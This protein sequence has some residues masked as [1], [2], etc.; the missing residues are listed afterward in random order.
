[1]PVSSAVPE[2]GTV[3]DLSDRNQQVVITVPGDVLTV[4]LIGAADGRMQWS[5]RSPISGGYLTMKAHTV[6][7]EDARISSGEQLSEWTFKVEQAATFPLRF[8]YHNPASKLAP[9]KVFSVLVVAD[10]TEA[11]LAAVLADIEKLQATGGTAVIGGFA[12]AGVEQVRYL[13]KDEAGATVASG[14]IPVPD[15]DAGFRHFEKT[16]WFALPRTPN[17]ALVLTPSV[18]DSSDTPQPMTV[19]AV[20]RTDLMTVQVFFGSEKLDPEA[21][22]TK[23]FPVARYLPKSA[24]VGKAALGALLAG[25]TAAERNERYF[26]SLPANVQLKTLEISNGL[27]RADF[28]PSLERGVGGSCRVAAI[29]AQLTETLKQF[30]AV[31]EVILSI[32]GR[33]EDIL[34][35]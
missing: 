6:T 29:R 4:P 26:T 16:V 1:M 30:P 20:F 31:R 23:A 24:S 32:D 33:T 14:V 3:L 19:P 11:Q 28:T 35:P 17:G 2:T 9:V 12:R 34:Q 10:R 21:T 13:L 27:A 15:A 8:E 18:G 22:C 7:T 5:F 25:P